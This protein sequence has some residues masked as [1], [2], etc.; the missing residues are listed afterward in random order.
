MLILGDMKTIALLYEKISREW[1]TA[2]IR[3]TNNLTEQQLK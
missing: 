1:S 3:Q 2:S